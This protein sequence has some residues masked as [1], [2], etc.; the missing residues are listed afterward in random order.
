MVAV[1]LA[2]ASAGAVALRRWNGR[3]AA[4]S[5]SAAKHPLLTA[6]E[7][8][9]PLGSRATLVQFSSSFCAPCRAARQLLADVAGRDTGVAH[10]EI[11]VA[12]R[13]D[14]VRLLDVRRTPT[15]FVL[16]PQGQITRRASGLPR[17]ED[18]VA[19][20]ALATSGPAAA[21]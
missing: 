14:L 10:V 11:D 12:D 21:R 13:L 3:L 15:V 19:A 4:A 7:L 1:V 20:V 17:R 16:G 2:L 6:A 18:L 5:R 8:G 9:Q